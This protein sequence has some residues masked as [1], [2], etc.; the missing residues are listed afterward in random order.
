MK[1]AYL[2]DLWDRYGYII[3]Y[4]QYNKFFENSPLRV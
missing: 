4:I 1:L 3:L 2:P